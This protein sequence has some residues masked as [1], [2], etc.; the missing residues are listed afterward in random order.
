MSN[1]VAIIF[2]NSYSVLLMFEYIFWQFR[3]GYIKYQEMENPV[4]A[5]FYPFYHEV[6][7]NFL[8]SQIYLS[9]KRNKEW[10]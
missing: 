10:R 1:Q 6:T 9:S 7:T 8:F 2:S 3:I 4:E 5:T